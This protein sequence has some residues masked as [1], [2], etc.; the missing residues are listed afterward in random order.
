M[1]R[2]LREYKLLV[3]PGSLK[4]VP[5]MTSMLKFLVFMMFHQ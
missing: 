3:M 5:T 2:L 1:G 4:T